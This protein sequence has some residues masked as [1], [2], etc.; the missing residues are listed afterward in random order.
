MLDL[1]G[2]KIG[3][4]AGSGDGINAIT[5][6]RNMVI[7]NG[8][9]ADCCGGGINNNGSKDCCFT[10]LQLYNNALGGL[11]TGTDALVDRVSVKGGTVG[12]SVGD[13]G[14][15]CSCEVTGIISGGTGIFAGQ[16]R[17]L[18]GCLATYC[19]GP[20]INVGNATLVK[21]CC[22]SGSTGSHA[23]RLNFAAIAQGCTA[24][25]NFLNGFEA[26]QRN[27][28]INCVATGNLQSG[29][30]ATYGGQVVGCFCDLNSICGIFSDA[31][32]AVTIRGNCCFENGLSNSGAGIRVSVASWSVIE[33]NA[34]GDN[35][36]GIDVPSN[37]NLI[38]A[39]R[40]V[41]N[42]NADYTI[43]AGSTFGPIV[44]ATSVG[45]IT[46]TANASHP[47]ANFRF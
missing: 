18:T 20:C 27:S 22:G 1:C 3:G 4:V 7:R 40:A 25:S 41:A 13:N 44:N 23:I 8:T 6:N 2:F 43:A 35:F 45:D 5:N 28:V 47:Q 34:I 24:N 16:N 11:A 33:G 46:A 9:I 10:D 42:T 31:G 17:V 14:R 39:N 29:I 32:G 30:H 12:I 38:F 26:L 15:V 21:D 36:R 19:A 37:R